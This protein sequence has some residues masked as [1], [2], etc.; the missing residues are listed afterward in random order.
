MSYREVGTV[1]RHHPKTVGDSEMFSGGIHCLQH[2]VE[3]SQVKRKEADT[4]NYGQG[5]DVPG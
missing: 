1:E 3:T 4:P 2:L 5:S